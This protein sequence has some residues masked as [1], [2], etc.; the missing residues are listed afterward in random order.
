MNEVINLYLYISQVDS[1][2]TSGIFPDCLAV[3]EEADSYQS[4]PYMD[5]LIYHEDTGPPILRLTIH[6]KCEHPP[7]NSVKRV[8]YPHPSSFLSASS[9]YNVETGQ[10]H[11]HA[12]LCSTKDEFIYWS[13]KVN[14]KLLAKGYNIE[15]LKNISL[16]Y[17]K[18]I[19]YRYGM[20][21]PQGLQ[22]DLWRNLVS[23]HQH[24]VPCPQQPS[25]HRMPANM[26]QQ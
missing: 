26:P 23:P 9:M 18:T 21:T 11:R 12:R 3:N 6:D 8:Q 1:Q 19:R 4:L 17:L 14:R 24:S 5:T 16:N 15:R 22:A 7:L 25:A 2:G 13:R 20:K 10:L